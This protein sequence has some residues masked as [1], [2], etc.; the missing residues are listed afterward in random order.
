MSNTSTVTPY[1]STRTSTGPGVQTA[2]GAGVAVAAIA[3]GAIVAAGT[4][5]VG[6]A[7]WLGQETEGDRQVLKRLKAN[8]QREA[9]GPTRHDHMLSPGAAPRIHS[10]ALCLTNPQPLL[11]TAATLG[12]TQV[13]QTAPMSGRD[14]A[15]VLLEHR[16][17]ER[18]AVGVGADGALR[19]H[20]A[21]DPRRISNLVRQHTVDQAR[22]HFKRQGMHVTTARQPNGEVQI[23]AREKAPP[24]GRAG[25]EVRTQVHVDG[26]LCVDVNGVR[27]ERCRDI[28]ASVAA[29]VG[30]QVEATE[31][32]DAYFDRTGEPTRT[33]ERV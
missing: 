24:A 28:V 6:V 4:C 21:G 20:T 31:L 11:H 5:A 19:V 26:S 2:T 18:L 29:A 32:K 7:R 10:E 3:A 14:R 27:G 25:G 15:Q 33:R 8:R 30:G 12:Y 1:A 9:L 23:L 22:A 17:G 13:S 16:T